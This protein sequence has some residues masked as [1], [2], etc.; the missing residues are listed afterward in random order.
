MRDALTLYD[1]EACVF[2]WCCYGWDYDTWLDL[3]HSHRADVRCP[4]VER[5]AH[6]LLLRSQLVAVPTLCYPLPRDHLI[7]CLLRIL[8]CKWR[9]INELQRLLDEGE[10]PSRTRARQTHAYIRI[11]KGL[12]QVSADLFARDN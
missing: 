8:A 4:D 1:L 7:A 9:A 6:A 12:T 11:T 5:H 10:C 3:S 2:G